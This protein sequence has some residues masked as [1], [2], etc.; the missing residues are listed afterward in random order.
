[1]TSMK[2]SGEYSV[3][4]IMLA[5]Y[6][7]F[8]WVTSKHGNSETHG[9]SAIRRGLLRRTLHASSLDGISYS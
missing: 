4:E 3:K 2:P 6:L 5:V 8:F 1:M 9:H 7:F